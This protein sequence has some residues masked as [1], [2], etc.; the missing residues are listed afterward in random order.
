M[1]KRAWLLGGALSVVALGAASLAG[2]QAGNDANA[3]GAKA[4]ADNCAT[5]HGAGLQGGEGPA[6]AGEQF[7][8]SWG[9]HNAGELLS[10]I[11][12]AMPPSNPGGLD[13]KTYVA[14]TRF[15]LARNGADTALDLAAAAPAQLSAVVLPLKAPAVG[16]AGFSG[17]AV[18]G[19]S[20]MTKPPPPPP[21]P[22]RFAGYTPVTEAMLDDPKPQNW[23]TWRRSHTGRGYSPLTQITAANVGQ[24]RLAWALP[25]P[26]GD[27]MAEPLVRDGVLYAFGF[28]DEVYAVDAADGHILW[29]YQRDLPKDARPQGKKTLAL[30]GDKVI[31]ATSDLHL[32]ALDARSGK[33]VWDSP[34][35][36]QDGLNNPGGPLAADG[37]II[38]GLTGQAKGGSLIAGFDAATGKQL[39]TF[40]T[41]P[42]PG[43]PGGDTWNGLPQ[44]QRSGGSSWTSGTYDAKTG[45]A[46]YGVSPTYDTKPLRFL[47]PGQ[48][49]DALYTDATIALDPHTGKLRWY[50]QHMQNDQW[51]FDWVFDR[52]IGDLDVN[53]QH[54]RTIMTSGKEGLFDVLDADT[55]KYLKTVDLGIQNF[56]Q[57]IDPKTGIKTIKPDLIPDGTRSIFVC[58]HG[59][60]GRNW[61]GTSFVEQSKRLFVVARDTCEELRPTKGQGLLSTGVDAVYAAPPHSDGK[62][63]TLRALD[64]QTGKI[65]WE[66]RQRAL[67]DTGVLTTAGGVLFAGSMDRQVQAFDQASGKVLWSAGLA[68]V[69]NAAPISFAVDGKQYV[70]FVTG[71]GN[72]SSYGIAEL[73]PE[74]QRPPVNSAAIYVFALPDRSGG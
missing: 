35:P 63:G 39:W 53:G 3:A 37:V 58:P 36:H 30:Y 59:G 14:I 49:N 43:E 27:N 26:N 6:L 60:G 62:Y 46:L 2:A 48:N 70:A 19:L 42:S 73:N 71:Y 13:A 33:A 10:F 8:A 1:D 66:H 31:A 5:C 38:Q 47:K 52:V 23:L 11:K 74:I 54:H 50:Y 34:I 17:E 44:D 29:R 45:V 21:R 24:L 67:F 28:G 18:G 57:S 64:M 55:G 65:A 25:L 16:S 69:P 9:G 15:I 22:N 72:P 68:G 32:V 41:I 40:H 20:T 12:S 56:V 7:L 61:F 51:D 4:Y